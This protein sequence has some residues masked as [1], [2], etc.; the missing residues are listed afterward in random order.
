MNE[1]LEKLRSIKGIGLLVIGLAAGVV[2]L[3][4]GTGADKAESPPAQTDE[5]FSFERY[6]QSLAD[7]LSEMIGRVE[8]VSDVHVMITL[9]RGYSEEFAKDGENYLTVKQSDGREETVILS[10]EAPE[11]KGV[12]V[13]CKGGD[14]PQ[15]VQ[16][17]ISLV[18]ALLNLPTNRIF[19]SAG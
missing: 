13:I 3:I 17:I 4:L 18:S 16:Q 12:A 6:E 14:E 10:R 7:R 19:V 15:I 1:L 8:G 9:E 11:V 2:L 5:E